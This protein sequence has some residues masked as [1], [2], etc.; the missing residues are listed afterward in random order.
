M[1]EPDER[2]V[3]LHLPWPTLLKAIAAVAVVWVWTQVVWVV[4]LLA[5]ALVIAAGLV[6]ASQWLERRGLSRG[7]AAALLVVAIVGAV[8]AFLVV[9]WSQLAAQ[10]NQLGARLQQ[11]EQQVLAQLPRSLVDLLQQAGGTSPA[12]IAPYLMRLGRGALTAIA[13]FVIAWILV[14][15]LLIERDAT[16][17]WVRGFVPARHRARFDRTSAEAGEAARGFV[18]GNVVTSTC[19]AI[20][21]F[22]WLSALG[23]PGAL[24]L[25]LLAF[26]FDFLPVLGFYLS[27]LPAMAMA[28]TV[29]S[30]LAVAMLPIYLSYDFIENYL[31]APR[32]YGNRL[33]LSKLAV[34]L[35]F[36][37][38]AQLA[39]IVGA[40][41][42]LPL[43]AIYPTIE[44]LW[45]RRTLGDDVVEAHRA[46]S[47]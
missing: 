28:A 9:S 23:V 3:S 37:V 35:A 26:V 43:A 33:R 25:A 17:Q 38:G 44:R 31:I 7:V 5:I 24:L 34:L 6:P 14:L 40:L 15:Y 36:A 19:A 39:G 10:G 47:A 21:F 20:Y 16:Y 46:Q 8:A 30:T 12:S 18:V 1:P 27:V 41:L 22:A 4:L 13:A 45:L 29:S 42:A 11:T 32:V 2:R